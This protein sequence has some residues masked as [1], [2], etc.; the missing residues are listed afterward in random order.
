[1]PKQLIIEA[2]LI[3]FGDDRGGVDHAVGEVVDVPKNTAATLAEL[4]RTLYVERKD[5]PDKHG[6]FTATPEL[7]KAAKAARTVKSAP[8]VTTASTVPPA[9]D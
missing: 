7:L 4:G 2:C 9:A 8:P 6:R 1:M 5:D 3:N